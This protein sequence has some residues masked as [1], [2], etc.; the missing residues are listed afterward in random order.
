MSWTHEGVRQ[1]TRSLLSFKQ[2]LFTFERDKHIPKTT[3][4][5][6]GHFRHIEDVANVHC[7][8]TRI[9]KERVLHSIFLAG[10]IAPDQNK[11]DEIL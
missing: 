9:Q 7:G 10:T 2:Y 11:L 1:A 3:N 4:S 8:L 6:E 5:L